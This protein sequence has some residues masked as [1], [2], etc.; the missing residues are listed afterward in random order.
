MVIDSAGHEQTETKADVPDSDQAAGGQ[1]FIYQR[2]FNRPTGLGGPSSVF[3]T[4]SDWRGCLQAVKLN[5]QELVGTA[6][7]TA[8]LRID[9][10]SLLELTNKI[11]IQ[12]RVTNEQVP[13][14]CGEVHLEIEED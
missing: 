3:L 2:S 14:L 13:L 12:L 5:Q 8:P 4:V 6:T 7:A 10:T 9:I 11:E 1:Q